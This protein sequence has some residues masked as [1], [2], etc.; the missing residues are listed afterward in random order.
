[1]DPDEEAGQ[2][3]SQDPRLLVARVG[4][5]SPHTWVQLYPGKALRTKLLAHK[6]KAD[7]SDDFYYVVPEL[8]PAVA[9]HLKVVVV[10]LVM[11]L[12]ASAEALLWPIKET[13]LSPYFKAVNRILDQGADFVAQHKFLIEGAGGKD[14]DC[15]IK[16]ALIDAE[17][18][19][20][21]LPSRS[22]GELLYEAM[23]AEQRVIKDPGHP[24][25]RTLTL[26]RTL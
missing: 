24:V 23:E 13:S 8:V 18:P 14:K 3:L 17:D 7:R 11:P 5:P 1:M 6:P 4:R 22:T 2:V 26:G 16:F 25:Y 15:T 21:V 12:T 19:A 10:H 20:P 9:K